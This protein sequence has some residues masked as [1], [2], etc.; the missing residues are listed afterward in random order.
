MASAD[1]LGVDDVEEVLGGLFSLKKDS[2]SGPSEFRC[3]C[4]VHEAGEEGHNPSC[5]I[6]LLTGYWNCFS[7]PASGD[8]VDLGVVVLENVPFNWKHAKKKTPE[9]QKWWA[10]RRNVKKLLVP[11]EP[12]AIRAAI[13]RR[14]RAARNAYNVPMAPKE[15]WVPIIP[16]VDAY[17]VKLPKFLR[18][19]DFTKEGIRP[20]NIRWVEK[21]TLMKE[22]GKSFTLD[23]AVAIPIYE[24]DETLIGWCY[25]ATN[26]SAEW[27]RNVRYIYTPGIQD[28]LNKLWFGI[29][30]YANVSEITVVEG[31]LDAVWLGQ[32][33]IPAVAILGNQTKQIEK[34]RGL[35]RFRKVNLF[36]DRDKTGALINHYLGTALQERGVPC[37]VS[38]FPAFALNRR[39]EP[40][41]DAQDLCGLD[42][43]LAHARAIPFILW[44]QRNRVAAAA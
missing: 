1:R 43:E 35:M 33:G 8:L 40:A 5:D 28:Q 20:W 15:R 3:L 24:E 2:R 22:D 30:L 36:C 7:C 16:P 39:G 6:N 25:R 42:L 29:H 31:A 19:R 10:A 9:K 18:E 37:T 27:F 32:H 26:T 44:K 17:E 21:A 38:R 12:D 4:P 13:Q 14:A 41:K 11:D 34:I 23:D